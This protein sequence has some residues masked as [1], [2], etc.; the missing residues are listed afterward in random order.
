MKEK[1][2]IKNKLKNFVKEKI[3]YEITD[4]NKSINK[5]GIEDIDA[6]V[7]FEELS[8]EFDVDFSKLDFERYGFN[9]MTFNNFFSDILKYFG[10]KKDFSF[11]HLVKVIQNKEWFDPD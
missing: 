4:W 1:K 2:I 8:K 11:N 9:A 6:F 10:K 5:L 3:G 7:F